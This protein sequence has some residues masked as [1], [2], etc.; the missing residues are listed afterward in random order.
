MYFWGHTDD[1]DRRIGEHMIGGLCEFTSKRRPISLV[2]S[3]NF[4]TRAEALEAEFRIKSWSRAKKEGLIRG[5]W[6]QV[7]FYA[8]PPSERAARAVR[9]DP[10]TSLGTNGFRDC[11]IQEPFMSSAVERP[12]EQ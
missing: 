3:E 11:T 1:L 4:G 12:G 6:T 8:Q 7:S 9:S 10:S 2:W 5:D